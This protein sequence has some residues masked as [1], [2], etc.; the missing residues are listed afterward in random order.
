M[1]LCCAQVF[2]LYPGLC[3]RFVN[4]FKCRPLVAGGTVT[5][6]LSMDLSIQCAETG[7]G[8]DKPGFVTIVVILGGAIVFTPAYYAL[9]LRR[10]RNKQPYTDKK[11]PEG[12]VT[13]QNIKPEGETIGER[14]SML[15]DPWYLKAFGFFYKSYERPY[16]W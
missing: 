7:F 6:Y 16:Y 3:L 8:L 11:H 9:C 4:M 1:C 13:P 14:L 5:W 15:D 10:Y 2:L 12:I